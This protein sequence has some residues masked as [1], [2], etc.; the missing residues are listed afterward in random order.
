MAGGLGSFD[1]S[2]LPTLGSSD[3]SD[4]LN[5]N[6]GLPQGTVQLPEISV[7]AQQGAA[8]A[9]APMTDAQALIA[10]A[11]RIGA[12]PLDYATVM[13]YESGGTFSPSKWGGVGGRHVGLIQ[14]GPNE[15]KAY[16]AHDGQSFQEQLPAVERYLTDRGFKPGM[17]RLDLYSTINAGR[18]G[19]YNASDAGNGGAPGS[20]LDKVRDQMGPHEAKAAA[21]LGGD[22][23]PQMPASAGGPARAAGFGT[24]GVTQGAAP[25]GGAAM[26]VPQDQAAP[27]VPD[28]L[29]S[30]IRA[31]SGMGG[32]AAGQGGQEQGQQAGARPFSPLA[33]PQLRRF[34]LLHF[35]SLLPGRQR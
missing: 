5:P 31:M 23:K 7:T 1:F 13:S 34:S 20:V 22:F 24:G 26:S 4:Y 12:D 11:K 14:F 3:P 9:Q 8:L 27:A 18:P 29:A 25:A 16:G 15:Q 10:S 35:P 33:D 28:S 17:G 2:R 6:I 32:G 21:F 30:A 19:L